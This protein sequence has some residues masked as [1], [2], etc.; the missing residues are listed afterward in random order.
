M[1]HAAQGYNCPDH[2][3]LVTCTGDLDTSEVLTGTCPI[4]GETRSVTVVKA[5]VAGGPDHAAPY[6]G[7]PG[8]EHDP[9]KDHAVGY[10]APKPVE[11]EAPVEEE[12]LE[13]IEKAPPTPDKPFQGFVPEEAP[14]G[15]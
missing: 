7:A 10:E 13:P 4:G 5:A 6:F 12:T 11:P 2:H 1:R 8:G 15:A 14:P 9:S 3:T